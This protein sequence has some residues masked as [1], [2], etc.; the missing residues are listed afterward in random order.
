MSLYGG[1]ILSIPLIL[2]S[3]FTISTLTLSLTQYATAQEI[4][5][6][7]YV[8]ISSSY[9]Y[10]AVALFA[11]LVIVC[12]LIGRSFARS[13]SAYSKVILQSG[14]G[15]PEVRRTQFFVALLVSLCAVLF[16]FC[17]SSALSAAT[18]YTFSVVL[19]FPFFLPSLDAVYGIYVL[20]IFIFSFS[21]LSI[22]E[23]GAAN[24]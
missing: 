20:V 4:L 5:A 23:L 22:G 24:K 7:I 10:V 17:L 15:Q 8:Q 14:G 6:S 16:A 9:T 11:G 1:A 2:N 13:S 18:L 21:A 19:R 3:I 12:Y